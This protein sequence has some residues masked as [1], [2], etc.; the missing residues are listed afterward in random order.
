MDKNHR[1]SLPDEAKKTNLL[2]RVFIAA[3][4]ILLAMMIFRDQP[5][6]RYVLLSFDVE[7]V[8][9]EQSVLDVL[10]VVYR[11][12]TSATFFVTGEYAEKHPEI[13]KLMTGREIACHGYSH[14]AF[15]E[16]DREEKK[17]ELK[18]CRQTIKEATGMG[19]IGFRA[20]Y[21]R[22]DRETPEI[23]E[24]EGFLYDA[25]YIKG[26]GFIFPRLRELK[27]GE[28]PVSSIFGIPLEDVVWLHYLKMPGAFFY[29]I[30]H[31]ETDLES[32]LF[33]PHHIA[34]QKQELEEFIN[35][36]KGQNVIFI[37]HRQ[38]IEMQ[39]EGV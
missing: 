7:P 20:P 6:K 36:L 29:V 34:T 26:L 14:K 8:D 10:D 31:K 11:T 37:S 12:N 13:V 25:S 15:T 5:D 4:V 16:M 39:D 9:G 21:N 24:Q 32:Y 23:L 2:F 1:T 17:E 22:I 27:I 19:V 30:K 18:K 28:I 35:Y 38:L 33:H 3:L